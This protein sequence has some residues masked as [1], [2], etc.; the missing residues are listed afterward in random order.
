MRASTVWVFN[1]T[2]AKKT[3]TKRVAKLCHNPNINFKI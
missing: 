3:P 1:L 2:K